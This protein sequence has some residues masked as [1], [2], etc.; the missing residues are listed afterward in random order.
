ME[1]A[2]PR[3]FKPKT[4]VSTWIK[5]FAGG[6]LVL[7]FILFAVWQMGSGITDAKMTG[8]VVAKD[9]KPMAEPE[10]QITIHKGGD[11]RSDKVDGDYI[12]TVEVLQ[13]DGTKKSYTV[14]LNEKA[15]YDSVKVGD[16][17]DVG[18]YLVR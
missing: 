18:P 10:K 2:T 13:K 17:F 7:A 5:A 14:W 16:N 1:K 6:L 9:F 4:S 12:I 15:R 3:V 11:V 8:I